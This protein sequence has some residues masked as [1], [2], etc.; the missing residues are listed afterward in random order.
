VL[1]FIWFD[2]SKGGV[3]WRVESRPILREAMAKGLTGLPLVPVG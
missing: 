3:D 1:G 2:Y